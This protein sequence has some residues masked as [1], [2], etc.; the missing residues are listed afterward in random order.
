MS[1]FINIGGT[2]PPCPI[3][4]DAP[5]SDPRNFAISIR[6]VMQ[7]ILQALP[8][9]TVKFHW[10]I[11]SNVKTR[12]CFN[13]KL[14]RLLTGLGTQDTTTCTSLNDSGSCYCY[15]YS[16]ILVRETDPVMP[17]FDPGCATSSPRRR[18]SND[19]ADSEGGVPNLHLKQINQS[20]VRGIPMPV[21]HPQSDRPVPLL[22]RANG[23][24]E[25]I[26]Q[27]SWAVH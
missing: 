2:C 12:S 13:T 14:S 9:Y 20:P 4:I 23:A 11:Y 6:L 7:S 17:N 21:N 27:H 16:N 25:Q 10:L 26:S 24:S 8:C 22:T 1:P 19:V 15:A 18:V 5:G 3:W